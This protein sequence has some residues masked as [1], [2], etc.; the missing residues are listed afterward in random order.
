ML[1]YER[2]R[3]RT[4]DEVLGQEKAV[5]TLSRLLERQWGGQA[6]WLSGPSGTG[7]TTLAR[8]VASMGADE[9]CVR[10]FDSARDLNAAALEEINQEQ[11]LYGWG[12]GG[13]AYI[14]NEAHRLSGSTV[15]R[16]LGMLERIPQHVVWVF[17]T[18]TDGLALFEE[19]QLDASPL[20]SRCTCIKLT[21]QGLNKTF[22]AH[23][24]RI[25]EAEGLDGQ[26][27]A[28]YEQLA[29]DCR[30]NCRMMLQ[31]VASGKMLD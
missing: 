7:K 12:K 18:T 13:R 17:T 11:S 23:V 29:R 15:D 10:E 14:V 6:F 30:N 5:K 28:K 22:A 21:S 16:L 8:I 27:I 31:E 2:Y 3:P 25:A 1:L 26:P 4:F 9:L 19:C 20:L 24:R